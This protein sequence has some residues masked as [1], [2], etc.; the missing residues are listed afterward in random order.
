MYK[1]PACTLDPTCNGV[2]TNYKDLSQFSLWQRMQMDVTL[3]FLNPSYDKTQAGF[4]ENNYS[5]RASL[6]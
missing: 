6:P 5:R 3:D 2:S 4:I 1:S